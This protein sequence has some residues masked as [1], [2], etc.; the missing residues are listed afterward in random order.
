MSINRSLAE[1]QRLLLAGKPEEAA[2]VLEN[3]LE[4]SP[5]HPH[6]LLYAGLA[7][8]ESELSRRAHPLSA[9][10]MP[11]DGVRQIET[12]ETEP[13]G[14]AV[15]ESGDLEA[16]NG[17]RGAGIEHICRAMAV[18]PGN[19]LLPVFYARALYDSGDIP[20]ALVQCQAV[21]Q[22]QP[23]HPGAQSLQFLCLGETDPLAGLA[24]LALAG[25]PDDSE[26]GGRAL[27]LAEIALLPTEQP[28]RQPLWA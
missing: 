15:A 21:L 3:E 6:L 5:D 16:L 4:R 12:G 28:L 18:S 13:T 27:C 19:H 20:G 26:I 11:A 1:G 17:H 10:S 8:V 23:G 2:R 7:R 9:N 24:G 22:A 14:A 25:T